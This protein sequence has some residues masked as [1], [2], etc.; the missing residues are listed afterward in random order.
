MFILVVI[1]QIPCSMNIKYSSIPAPQM[2]SVPPL[3]KPW[4][5]ERSSYVLITLQMSSSSSSLTA[6]SIT[7]MKSLY[8]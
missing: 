3:L 7:T 2:W 4:Q 8:N 5:W 6:V 1:M